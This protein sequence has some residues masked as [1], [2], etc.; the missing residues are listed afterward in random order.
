MSGPVDVL[1]TIDNFIDP[2]KYP[3]TDNDLVEVRFVIEHLIKAAIGIR[4]VQELRDIECA[5]S[6]APAEHALGELFFALSKIA[7]IE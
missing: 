6:M 7:P 4:E 2:V 3:G 5:G 1:G